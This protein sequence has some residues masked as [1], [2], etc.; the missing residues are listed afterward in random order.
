MIR[1]VADLLWISAAIGAALL[2]G[3]NV[4]AQ[5]IAVATLLVAPGAILLATGRAAIPTGGARAVLAVS[6]SVVLLMGLAL[7]LSLLG[8]VVGV[9]RPLDAT[10]AAPLLAIIGLSL[11][12]MTFRTGRSGLHYM[13]R[14]TDPR[15]LRSAGAGL[16]LPVAAVLGAER[17]NV[18]LPG[19]LALA[20]TV[21]SALLLLGTATLTLL[22]RRPPI[23]TIL[24]FVVLATAYA[25]SARGTL[26]FGWDIQKEFSIAVETIARGRWIVP[27]DHDAYAAMLSLTGLPALIGV[28]GSLTAAETFRFVFPVFSA[29][30]VVG[31]FTLTRRFADR[32]PALIAVLLLLVA[33]LA[34]PRGMQGIARQEVAFLL[35]AALLI[36]AFV[37]RLGTNARRSGVIFLG[38]GIAVAHYS[39]GYTTVA[40]LGTSLIAGLLL[41]RLRPASLRPLI[42]SPLVVLLVTAGVLGWNV[43]VHQASGEA[44]S[45]S[46]SIAQEGL[47]ILPDNGSGDLLSSWINGA[48]GTQVSAQEYHAKVIARTA[49]ADWIEVATGAADVTLSDATAER[50]PGLLPAI[51]GLYSLLAALVRQGLILLIVVAVFSALRGVYLGRSAVGA[52]AVT[53]ALAALIMVVL[54]RLS[55]TVANFYNPERGALHA[56]L[57]YAP[58][59]AILLSSLLRRRERPIR[60]GVR[61]A[62]AGSSTI[63]LVSAL[64]LS[65]QLF[66]GSPS[67]VHANSGEEYERLMISRAEY[68]TAAWLGERKTDDLVVFSDRYGQLALISLPR[69]QIDFI[70]PTI[71]PS[72]VD[73]L[74]YVYA[75][76]TN[77]ISDRSRGSEKG[78]FAVFRFPREFYEG[79]R[80]IVYAT[81]VTRVYR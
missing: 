71:D 33:S 18:G 66:G 15:W 49:T 11:G 53:L 39:T 58:A 57:I 73:A 59:V 32:G 25:A 28:V 78:L 65:V 51:G 45:L 13:A 74:A 81:E 47:Q 79:S 5:G 23:A 63:A 46:F 21:L 38:L 4:V 34:L 64:A 48:G 30:T 52:E 70:G 72:G 41:R 26:L 7:A 22:G 61:L 29:L 3:Q 69:E 31:T 55:T 20:V 60:I 56:A 24:F 12:A 14:G 27:L 36:V 77:I 17:L 40:L 10:V 42:F 8:P 68:A 54:L 43:G 6:L 62:V 35:F 76:R 1:R 2:P 37:S 19:D 67:A 50:I 44:S 75:S 9:E 80:A 16:L